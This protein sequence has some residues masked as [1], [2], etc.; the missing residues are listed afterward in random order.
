MADGTADGDG[1]GG[2]AE[3]R[4]AYGRRIDPDSPLALRGHRTNMVGVPAQVLSTAAF[5]GSPRTLRI[6]GTRGQ[7]ADLFEALDEAPDAD[8]AAEVFQRHL[9]A[10]FDLNP[11][12]SG[13]QGADGKRRFRASYLRLLKGWMFDSNNAEGA[14]LKGWV[15]SRF[16]LMPTYHK[17][18]IR[19]FAS[20]AWYRYGEE[21][22]A[23]R[24]HNNNIYL[25]LDLLY[26]YCQWWM[27]RGWPE[28]PM[29]ARAMAIPLYRGVNDFEEHFILE[30]PDK[31]SAV[32]RLNNLC[33]FST[34]RE[35]AGQ[36]G[37]YILEAR[38]PVV[39]IVFFRDI[40]PRYPFRGEGEYLVVGGDYRVSVSLL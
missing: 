22:T 11:D 12:F 20:G 8:R 25:Q 18:P 36:F 27:R 6:H 14:V 38:V 17:E 9:A 31:R 30:R 21:K 28:A 39:K 19:R 2:A 13:S 7:H 3:I 33:S 40:L 34:D 26:E 29:P 5:N 23:T 35:I 4:D 16:G 32:L 15:E 10:T 1:S 24:F 37:D